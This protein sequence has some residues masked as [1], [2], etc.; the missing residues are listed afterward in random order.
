MRSFGIGFS[1]GLCQGN[2]R[3]CQLAEIGLFAADTANRYS[4]FGTMT[5][6]C[7]PLIVVSCQSDFPPFLKM[8]W[9]GWWPMSER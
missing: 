1:L 5:P 2:E 8:I 7:S 4:A 3:L 6:S 9:F